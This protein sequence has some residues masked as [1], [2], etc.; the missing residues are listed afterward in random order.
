MFDLASNSET[1][2]IED[3][4]SAIFT[5]SGLILAAHSGLQDQIEVFDSNL[6]MVNKVTLSFPDL[7]DDISID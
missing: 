3:I 1:Q 5:D 7:H 2:N 4:N 6:N